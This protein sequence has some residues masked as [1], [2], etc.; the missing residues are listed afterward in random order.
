MSQ[1]LIQQENSV[2]KEPKLSEFMYTKMAEM[3]EE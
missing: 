2:A 1:L 3:A